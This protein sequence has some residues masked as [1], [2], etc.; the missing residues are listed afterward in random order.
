MTNEKPQ[1]TEAEARAFRD[2]MGAYASG[3]T[4]VTG[5]DGDEP[6]GFTCQSFSS[7]SLDPMLVSI[8]VMKSSTTYPRIRETGRFA[9][10]VLTDRQAETS[11]RFARRGT[12]KWA[13]TTWQASGAGNPLL[14][15]ALMSACCTIWQ[16]LDAGDHW[17]VLGEVRE[18][19]T[20]GEAADPLL[21]YRGAYRRLA[22]IEAVA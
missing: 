1:I 19:V 12:D 9:V 3:V 17:I 7:V 14:E 20:G 2:A 15:A 16:E 8:C 18:L 5:H 4:V 10:N 21:F 11:T 22:A 6:I 13:G